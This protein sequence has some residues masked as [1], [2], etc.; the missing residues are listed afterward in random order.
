ML[1]NFSANT[2]LKVNKLGI[3]VRPMADLQV[4]GGV[5]KL[6]NQNYNTWSTCI[7]SYMQGQDLWEVVDGTEKAQLEAEDNNRVL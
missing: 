6:N 4:V 5:K 3:K 2:S 1:S 7:T